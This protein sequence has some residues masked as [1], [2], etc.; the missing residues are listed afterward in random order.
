[1]EVPEGQTSTKQTTIPKPLEPTSP[2]E[3][4][5]PPPVEPSPTVTT[6]TEIPKEL[7]PETLLCTYGRR[8]TSDAVMASD[9]LC[10]YAFYDSLYAL[11]KNKLSTL[12]PFTTDLETFMRRASKYKKTSSGVA[13]AFE[14][15]NDA[16]RDL[17][18]RSLSPLTVFW[19]RKIFHAGVLD[20][21]ESPKPRQWQHAIAMLK[22][23]DDLL[24]SQRA[25]GH[26]AITVFTAPF[27]ES[28]WSLALARYFTKVRFNPDLLIMLGHYPFGDNMIQDCIVMPPTRHPD[29]AAPDYVLKNYSYDLS[30]GAFSLRE[31]YANDGS[32][33]GMLS[34]TLK[35]RWTEPKTRDA[36]DFYSPCIYDPSEESFGS[37]T[38]VCRHSR[39]VSWLDYSFSHYAMLA[40]H[41]TKKRAFAY[42]NEEG[43]YDKLCKVKEDVQDVS[44]GIAAY[45]VDYD[46]YGNQCESL[47]LY[48]RHS[49]LK[50]LRSIVDYFRTLFD[51]QFSE[52]VCT[53]LGA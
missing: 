36:M 1:M 42:D 23:L 10:D 18:N 49:R 24:E 14:H 13:F 22:K 20:T 16:E 19:W 43:I 47:N 31:F 48:G 46:D 44:F 40:R 5:R 37:Y 32:S 26:S 17:K 50:A 6:P 9:G 21:P 34:V 30:N 41:A 29:D 53:S 45:D 2:T 12:R 11:D 4:R 15:L 52:R 38:E 33:H 39:Y 8:T 3:T 35:G 51:E 28:D 7:G 25:L 27:P